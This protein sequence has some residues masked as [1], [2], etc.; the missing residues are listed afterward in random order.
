MNLPEAMPAPNEAVLVWTVTGWHIGCHDGQRWFW[1]D[2]READDADADVL[3]WR[4]LPDPP[5]EP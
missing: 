2:I 3:C 1:P 4:P 5:E